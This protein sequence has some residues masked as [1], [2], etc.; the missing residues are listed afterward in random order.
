MQ[1]KKMMRDRKER[2]SKDYRWWF[3]ERLKGAQRSKKGGSGLYTVYTMARQ[4]AL[5]LIY[6]KDRRGRLAGDLGS[7]CLARGINHLSRRRHAYPEDA[8]RATLP[9]RA[10]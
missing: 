8:E 9:Y 6:E 5:R 7:Y 1:K 4:S 3:K 2:K 10:W